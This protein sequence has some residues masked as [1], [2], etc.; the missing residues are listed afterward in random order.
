MTTR[1]Y[2]IGVLS[3]S[4]VFLFADQNLMAPNLSLMADEFG[5][6]DAERDKKLGGHVALAF[7]ILGAPA[8]FIIGWAADKYNRLRL[9]ALVIFIGEGACAYTYWTTTYRGLLITRALTGV[10]VGGA[11]PLIFSLLSDYFGS[12]HR[13]LV[14][15]IVGGGMGA[16]IAFGQLLAGFLSPHGWRLPF[17]IVAIPSFFCAF[18]MLFTMTEPSRGEQETAVRELRAK[19]AAANKAARKVPS[20]TDSDKD[21]VADAAAMAAVEYK[22]NPTWASF[23][24]LFKR[25]PLLIFLQGIPGCLPWGL[26]YT[27]LNDFLSN[28]CGLSVNQATFVITMFGVGCFIGMVIG[29]FLGQFLHNKD[30]RY[31]VVLMV[32]AELLGVVPLYFLVNL[33]DGE[34]SLPAALCFSLL[35]GCFASVTGPNARAVLQNTTLP[36]QRGAAFAM[37]STTDDLGKGFG[38]FIIALFVGGMGRIKAFNIILLGWVLGGMINGLLWFY[39]VEDEKNCQDKVARTI[40]ASVAP[41]QEEG[42]SD[43]GGEETGLM[44]LERDTKGKVAAL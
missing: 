5:F 15:A 11:T 20:A 34:D 24:A 1:N 18:L 13:N 36:D 22:P 7:F 27:F 21:E 30:P 40:C 33:T 39:V 28:D 31:V 10:S 6:T 42:R 38:P 16:G 17:L 41:D 32:V 37:M 14:S 12:E 3:L 43:S 44:M 19:T 2:C 26:V 25:S 8:S 9:F 35:G 29:G 23:R 4:S